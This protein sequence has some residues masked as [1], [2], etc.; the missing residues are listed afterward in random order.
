MSDVRRMPLAPWLVLLLFWTGLVAILMLV[1]A[2]NQHQQALANAEIQADASFK[3]DLAYRQWATMHGGVYVPVS[4]QTPPNPY[5][6]HPERDICTPSGRSLTLLNPAY[7]TRQANQLAK[8]E[9]GL[10]GHLTSLRPI[11]Q[12]N[13]ADPWE[14]EA[15]V[16]FEKE[17]LDKVTEQ[18]LL[19]GAP[20][21][22]AMYPLRTTQGC[23]HCHSG[24]GH[25]IGD[26]RGGISISVPLTPYLAGAADVR[27]NH[28][29][30]L[31]LVWFIGLAGIGWAWQVMRGQ[32]SRLEQARHTAHQAEE[33]YHSLFNDADYGIAIVDPQSQKIIECNRALEDMLEM[34]QVELS[35]QPQQVLPEVSDL[36]TSQQGKEIEIP[37]SK[38][39]LRIL[40]VKKRK[41]QL[42]G[43][44]CDQVLYY[45]RTDQRYSERELLATAQ[46]V[47]DIFQAAQNIA[48]VIASYN[49]DAPIL[50]FSPGA[51]QIFG[52]QKAEVIGKPVQILHGP[53]ADLPQMQEKM[54]SGQCAFSGRTQLVR[55]GGEV[56]PALFSLYPLYD[57]HRQLYAGLGISIDISDMVE[58]E[59]RLRQAQKLESI[60]TLAGG[61]AH[62][63]NNILSIIFGYTQLAMRQ[64][65]EG[66]KLARQLQ[67]I[68]SAA[69]RAKDL[70]RQILTFSRKTSERREAAA[71]QPI[72]KEGL[73]ML[74]ATLPKTIEIR[75]Q[76]NPE[77]G[78]VLADPTQM[79]QILM[80]LCTNAYHAMRQ[81]GGVLTV[82]LDNC[83]VDSALLESHPELRA[84]PYAKLTIH[85]TGSGIEED[86]LPRIFDPFFTTKM[87]Q[88][89]TG[90]G[91][92]VVHGIVQNHG[93][94]VTVESEIGKGSCFSIFLPITSPAD[95]LPA[96]AE[97]P[98]P[99]GHEQVLMV[100]DEPILAALGR[101]L[102][103]ALGYRVK[104]CTDPR[105]A[106]QLV[107]E[108]PDHFDL[109]I[110]DQTMP[111]LTGAE[112]TEKLL[113]IRPELP[114]IIC[115]G[116]SDLINKKNYR[117][118][119][120]RRLLNK[121][122]EKDQLARVIREILAEQAKAG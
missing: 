54:Q 8:E 16:R 95:P 52:Y 23:L 13:L 28:L 90:M 86:I 109:V 5:L 77:T 60:G 104:I 110:T 59:E 44:E 62:D 114:V 76:I 48:F 92:S 91:L 47:R 56:F 58:L 25:K 101:D 18:V 113:A 99:V 19:D 88:E 42:A 119:G 117:N 118:C 97:D 96:P 72:I 37:S 36:P 40:E 45:D 105:K 65:E 34:P 80:N 29:M 31:G 78:K 84:G 17:S 49:Q 15:L 7:M 103:G 107:E 70:V 82:S 53:G 74:R 75:E 35:G 66:S 100:D 21:L 43:K 10:Q 1:S 112:L 22:R 61:I 46:R 2:R 69:T 98:E 9:Y 39:F 55:K 11:R 3:K 81:S 51:E 33:R 30:T 116:Y 32:F 26:I 24:Q 122:L 102:L 67:T 63:F 94:T 83:Q 89:G 50:E 41:I 120:A 71:L 87:A 27:N 79:H 73:K 12:E 68:D 64:V 6:E 115:T 85:D 106:L 38:G 108:H 57:E 4:E 93:G 20:F 14:A 121:P 111:H